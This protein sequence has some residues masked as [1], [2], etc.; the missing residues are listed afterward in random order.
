MGK[1]MGHLAAWAEPTPAINFALT[2][3][4]ALHPGYAT[5]LA[6][7][8]VCPATGADDLSLPRH[9]MPP[10][11]GHLTHKNELLDQC[12]LPGS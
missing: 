4:E 3:G 1:A 6:P 2:L 12:T 10:K 5:A 8:L 11:M 9:E 7:L